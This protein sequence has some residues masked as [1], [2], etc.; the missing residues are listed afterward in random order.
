MTS[1]FP[2][3]LERGQEFLGQSSP[4][5]GCWPGR[6][7]ARSICRAVFFPSIPLS[8]RWAWTC[9][10]PSLRR[11]FFTRLS[12]PFRFFV[13]RKR[14]ILSAFSSLSSPSDPS[15]LLPSIS[16]RFL[17]FQ[18]H[19]AFAHGAPH[20]QLMVFP[21]PYE[22]RTGEIDPLGEAPLFSVSSLVELYHKER[23]LL[24]SVA[25]NL[26]RFLASAFPN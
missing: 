1:F 5:A 21:S 10:L 14:R 6:W 26:S 25:L 9:S 4:R 23:R 17:L 3:V 13:A 2:A 16:C 24:V 7:S 20:G 19:R 8:P 12:L 15:A 11:G 22:H 18:R